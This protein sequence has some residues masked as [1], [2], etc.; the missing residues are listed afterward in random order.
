MSET[1]GTLFGE[2]P[3]PEK[4]T[5]CQAC[6]RYGVVATRTDDPFED[7]WR[8]LSCGVSGTRSWSRECGPRHEEAKASA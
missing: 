3:G 8:C 6:G 4:A 1:Q 7:A 5:V 2:A